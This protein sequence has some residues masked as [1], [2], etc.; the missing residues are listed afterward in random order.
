MLESQTPDEMADS[1][2]VLADMIAKETL[3]NEQALR[4]LN[5]YDK[6]QL[7]YLPTALLKRAQELHELLDKRMEQEHQARVDMIEEAEQMNNPLRQKKKKDDSTDSKKQQ[8]FSDSD[9]D[10]D[11]D[12]KDESHVSELRIRARKKAKAKFRLLPG[13]VD[14]FGVKSDAER[15]QEKRQLE[16]EAAKAAEMTPRLLETDAARRVISAVTAA[17]TGRPM[18]GHSTRPEHL[19]WSRQLPWWS[20][21]HFVHPSALPQ[22]LRLLRSPTQPAGTA[23][24]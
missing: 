7:L 15:A 17:N 20:R 6:K 21:V 19:C 9:D 18:T 10:D 2:R 1:I 11:A 5:S 3:E 22:S 13:V 24:V 14:L 8:D 4:V 12:G 16:E 23:G